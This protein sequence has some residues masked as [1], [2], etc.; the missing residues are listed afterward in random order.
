MEYIEISLNIFPKHIEEIVMAELGEIGF[1]SF[2]EQEHGFAAY[3]QADFFNEKKIIELPVFS[4]KKNKITYKVN[5]IAD[6]N[7]NAVWESNFDPVNVDTD[8]F[9][10]AS[11]HEPPAGY[12]H[13]IQINPK[14][15]FGTGHH[16]TT[17][18][19]LKL[20]MQIDT[21]SKDFLDMGCGTAVLA[22]LAFQKNAKSITAIDN[23]DWAFENA[24]E[25]VILNN[26]EK[27]EVIKGDASSLEGKIF[28]IIFANINRN[29]LLNDIPDYSKSLT[30]S[31]TL[32]VSGFYLEDLDAIKQC[33]AQSGL[34]FERYETRN[35]WCAAIFK[36]QK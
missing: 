23:D 19:M 28:D 20:L 2:V 32:A 21:S 15:S 5:R 4:D 36:K 14:M 26:A 35:N 9:V 8:V 17:H 24:K 30:T 3:I 1:E 7:W 22:L 16:E 29:I 33:C 27:I 25:N 31:G 11:F 34:V 13:Y 10:Y 12:K 18:L 6:Q